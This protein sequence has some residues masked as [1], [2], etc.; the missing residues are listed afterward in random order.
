MENPVD[1]E[2]AA[3]QRL[4]HRRGDQSLHLARHPRIGPRAQRRHEFAH[5][6]GHDL[7]RAIAP[8]LRSAQDNRIEHD[9][10]VHQLGPRLAPEQFFG[11]AIEDQVDASDMDAKMIGLGKK[12]AIR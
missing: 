8:G 3:G 2:S 10:I 6:F 11:I 5:R 4:G 1:P 12:D 7:C 9:A